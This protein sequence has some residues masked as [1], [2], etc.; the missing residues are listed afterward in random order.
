[1]CRAI[2]DLQ[3]V[4]THNELDS[5]HHDSTGAAVVIKSLS[6]QFVLVCLSQIAVTCIHTQVDNAVKD[7]KTFADAILETRKVSIGVLWDEDSTN[8]RFKDKYASRKD[9]PRYFSHRVPFLGYAFRVEDDHGTRLQYS[10]SQFLIF[11]ATYLLRMHPDLDP[12]PFIS[13]SYL[14]SVLVVNV[15]IPLIDRSGS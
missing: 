7:F 11:I 2:P 4:A 1:M 9:T 14:I 5:P 6:T 10:K 3:T 15:L 13:Q 12:T 8:F